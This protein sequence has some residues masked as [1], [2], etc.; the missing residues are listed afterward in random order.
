MRNAGKRLPTYGEF[1]QFAYGC[2]EGATGAGA[3]IATGGVGWDPTPNPYWMLSIAN[4]D[5]P[6]GNINQVLDEYSD[7]RNDTNAYGW[8]AVDAGIASASEAQ[9]SVYAQ[10]LKQLLA[11]GL[12]LNG[13]YAGPRCVYCY[14][15]PWHVTAR[16]G[17]R[18]VSDSLKSVF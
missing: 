14:N 8:T 18:G 1:L 6:S 7:L 9:G 13:G 10:G 12:W 4:V 3:R 15:A 17:G 16:S 5:Q 11:G 2:P